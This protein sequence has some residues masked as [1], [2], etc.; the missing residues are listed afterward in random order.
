[1]A[2]ETHH[3]NNHSKGDNPQ[4]SFR[5]SF[6]FVLLLVLVFIAAVNFVNVMGH[7]EG[8]EGEAHHEKTEMTSEHHE[9][10]HEEA[11]ATEAEAAPAESATD[12]AAH[13]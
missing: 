10:N 11:K 5:S 9:A 3:D 12:S 1:M 6:W 7:D 13:H 4:T 2:H 8:G